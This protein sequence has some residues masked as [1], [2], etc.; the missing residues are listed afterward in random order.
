MAEV[1]TVEQHKARVGLGLSCSVTGLQ[2]PMLASTANFTFLRCTLLHFATHFTLLCALQTRST[3]CLLALRM[4]VP[5][6][7]LG[8]RPDLFPQV[9]EGWTAVAI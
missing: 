2:V 5:C 7:T 1:G 8:C 4:P 9:R 3:L 6:L